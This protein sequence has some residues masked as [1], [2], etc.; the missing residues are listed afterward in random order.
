MWDGT[1]ALI[2][3]IVRRRKAAKAAAEGGD[4]EDENGVPVKRSAGSESVKNGDAL[5]RQDVESPSFLVRS[6]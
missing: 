2:A 5:S 3:C 4:D 6:K 1:T